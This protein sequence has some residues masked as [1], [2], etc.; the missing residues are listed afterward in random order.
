MLDSLSREGVDLY[1]WDYN[2]FSTFGVFFKFIFR[3]TGRQLHINAG[4]DSEGFEN[5]SDYW[6]DSA[7]RSN[8]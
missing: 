5:F 7:G 6:S 1:H 3:R 8:I 4:R 2:Q